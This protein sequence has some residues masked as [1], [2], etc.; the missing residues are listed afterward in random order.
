MDKPSASEPLPA[1][2]ETAP[3]TAH[4]DDTVSAPKHQIKDPSA[5]QSTKSKTTE[6][7]DEDDELRNKPRKDHETTTAEIKAT[8]AKALAGTHEVEKE[9]EGLREKGEDPTPTPSTGTKP[10]A[11]SDARKEDDGEADVNKEPRKDH[12][13]TTTQIKATQEKALAGTHKAEKEGEALRREEERGEA[14]GEHTGGADGGES[15]DVHPFPAFVILE[16]G[17][18]AF[19][20]EGG[21][22]WGFGDGDAARKRG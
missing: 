10:D 18:G 8:Q 4:P 6:A 7:D 12:E 20:D 21:G 14:K 9:G 19:I 22:V 3:T 13:A 15:F 17:E 1:P 16:G 11:K 5:D 2:T